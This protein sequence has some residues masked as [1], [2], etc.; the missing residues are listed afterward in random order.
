MNKPKTCTAMKSFIGAFRAIS[1]CFPRY[2]SLL[3]PLEESIKGI[4]GAQLI[5]WTLQLESCFEEAQSTLES[6]RALT[7]PIPSDKLVL[8]VDASPLNNGLGAT[9]FILRNNKRLLAGFYSF[10]LRTHQIGWFPCELE[11]LAFSAGVHHFSQ[12]ARESL[13]PLQVLTDSKPCVQAYQRPCIF[14][15]P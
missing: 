11:A 6:P 5:T 1:R 3:S 4:Q 7:I 2:S 14:G 15:M 9:L 8:T 13:F 10:K 12:F